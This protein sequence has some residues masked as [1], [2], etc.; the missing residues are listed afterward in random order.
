MDARDD[1]DLMLVLHDLS[2]AIENQRGCNAAAA[3]ELLAEL[4][5]RVGEERGA[6]LD[7]S[8]DG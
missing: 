7:E 2:E 4:I 3:Q 1:D 8:N 6:F 5:E